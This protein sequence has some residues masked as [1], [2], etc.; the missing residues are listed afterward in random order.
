MSFDFTPA[1]LDREFP[2]RKSLVYFNHAGVAPLPRRVADAM[3]GHVENA[4]D[5]GAADWRRAFG[6]VEKARAKAARFIGAGADEIAFLPNTSWAINLVALAFPWTTGDNVVT[7]DLE[8]PSNS[9]PWRALEARGVECRVAKSRGGPDHARRRSPR[10]ATRGR[11]SSPFPGSRFTTAGSFPSRSSPRSAGSAASSWSSTRSRGWAS[12]RWTSAAR[13][14]DVLAADAHKWLYGP[15]GCAVF[16]VSEE[17]RDRV[18]AIVSGWWSLKTEGHYLDYRGAPYASARRYEPGTLPIDHVRALSACARSSRRDG[19]GAVHDRV[20]SLVR[21]L[22]DGLTARS[23]RVTSPEPLAS[24]I[25]AAVPP[26]GEAHGWAK[27]L[28]ERDVIVAP[29]EGAV[30][31]SPHAGNDPRGSRRARSPRSTRSGEPKSRRPRRLHRSAFAGGRCSSGGKGQVFETRD[32]TDV[33]GCLGLN[34]VE[35]TKHGSVAD[36]HL[37]LLTAELGGNVLLRLTEQ[38]GEA[39]WCENGLPPRIDLPGHAPVLTPTPR[40][41]PR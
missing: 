8:F 32:R 30:R 41:G 3:I 36:E 21:A 10:R 38:R 28:E 12:C 19:T 7:D 9:Y 26:R 20:L 22:A 17:A 15:E 11:G 29:R 6:D 13:A 2:V 18:P 14:S 23:W 27:S 4:R 39:Y 16:Y 5:R 1:N 24:G 35:T 40:F 31:F 37:R 25:L 34:E 33:A